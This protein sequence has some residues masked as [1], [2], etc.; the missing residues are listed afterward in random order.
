MKF[1]GLRKGNSTNEKLSEC[2]SKACINDVDEHISR[3]E[4]GD[5]RLESLKRSLPSRPVLRLVKE[6]AFIRQG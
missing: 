2:L 1:F 3:Q 4:L 6:S 5:A